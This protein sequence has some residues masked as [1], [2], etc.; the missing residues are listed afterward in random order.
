MPRQFIPPSPE[1]RSPAEPCVLLSP[2]QV[3]AWYNQKDSNQKAIRVDK[4]VLREVQAM[5]GKMGWSM[6][7]ISG[8]QMLLEERFKK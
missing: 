3:L 8:H 1:E 2:A 6:V 5:A 7:S 4:D